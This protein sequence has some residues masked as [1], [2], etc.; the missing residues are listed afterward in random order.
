[1]YWWFCDARLTVCSHSY[2]FYSVF[3]SCQ[4]K[5]CHAGVT[6]LN[7][8]FRDAV[9]VTENSLIV[10]TRKCQPGDNS[11]VARKFSKRTY[12]IDLTVY[13]KNSLHYE[14]DDHG[15]LNISIK[16]KSETNQQQ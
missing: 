8:T 10:Q 11:I 1:M 6:R 3:N 7:S 9:E 12:P 5:T 2:E 16:P 14:F 15:M 13:D 4:K